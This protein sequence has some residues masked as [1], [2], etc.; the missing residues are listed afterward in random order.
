MLVMSKHQGSVQVDFSAPVPLSLLSVDISR[1]AEA[2]HDFHRAW[3]QAICTP[4]PD[5]ILDQPSKLQLPCVYVVVDVA[6]RAY[7]L[8]DFV[9]WRLV[10]GIQQRTYANVRYLATGHRYL[11]AEHQ[12]R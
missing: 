9:L 2:E 8:A 7:N 3:Q 12:Y 4:N 6:Q 5:N 11:P 1:L 10:K